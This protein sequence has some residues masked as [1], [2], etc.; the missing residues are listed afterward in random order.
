M[1]PVD[2]LP[3]RHQGKDLGPSKPTRVSLIAETTV[4]P[5]TPIFIG[6]LGPEVNEYILVFLFQG[7]FPSC[8][9]AKIATDQQ[10]GRSRGYA[11]N[12]AFFASL[13][14]FNKEQQQVIIEEMRAQG[15]GTTWE[16]F[17]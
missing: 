2:R 10:T 15:I 5:S 9:S 16:A 3:W 17:R 8:K 11:L 1:W 14:P 4:A 7:N 12:V 13:G 6:D